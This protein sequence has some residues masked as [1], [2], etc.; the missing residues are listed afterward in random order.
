MPN[1]PRIFKLEGN[2]DYITMFS[3]Q[4]K[5]SRLLQ[6]LLLN[7]KSFYIASLAWECTATLSHNLK[8]NGMKYDFGG[9]VKLGQR[10]S[11]SIYD[12]FFLV[13]A[14]NCLL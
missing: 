8:F 11:V 10:V 7:I 1:F 14:L 9:S 13:R 4:N 5:E 12:K 6:L 3:C 2:D